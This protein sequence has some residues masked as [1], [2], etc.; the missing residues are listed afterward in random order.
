MKIKEKAD[1]V[2]EALAHEF[3]FFKEL[4]AAPSVDLWKLIGF[5]TKMDRTFEVTNLTVQVSCFSLTYFQRVNEST[6]TVC[7]LCS[8]GI[9]ACTAIH[10]VGSLTS[11]KGSS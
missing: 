2:L 5:H 6:L 8:T 10:V 3:K 11:H 7:T 4:T 9:W 1:K